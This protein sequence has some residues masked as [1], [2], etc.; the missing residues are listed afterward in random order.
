V[1]QESRTIAK[2]DVRG[3]AAMGPQCLPLGIPGRVREITHVLWTFC[4][5]PKQLLLNVAGQPM[6]MPALPT[7]SRSGR[8]L[9]SRAE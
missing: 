8:K 2:E 1:G 7:L 4:N 9:Y 6:K 5:W 3:H